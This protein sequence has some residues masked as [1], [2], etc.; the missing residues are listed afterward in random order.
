MK[1]KLFFMLALAIAMLTSCGN[2]TGSKGKAVGTYN[3]SDGTIITK[4][5]KGN[6]VS[7]SSNKGSINKVSGD[8]IVIKKTNLEK[9]NDPRMLAEFFLRYITSTCLTRYSLLMNIMWA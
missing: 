1:T 5:Q 4:F 6:E 9:F 3:F 2:A 8:I 7:Y